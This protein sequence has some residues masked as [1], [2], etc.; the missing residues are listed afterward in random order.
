MKKSSEKRPS[1]KV[2]KVVKPPKPYPDFPLTPHN[3]GK[4]Q[5][6]IRNPVTGDSK[7]W[8]FGRWGKMVAGKME[9][10]PGDGWQEALA[11]YK[12]QADDLH[13]GRTPRVKNADGLTLKDLC[14]RFLTEKT[15]KKNAG[16]L[17]ERSLIDYRST[18]DRL[19]E[20]FGKDRLVDDIAAD[21]FGRLRAE[22]TKTWGP[23]RLS[24]EITRIKSVF[25]F[26]FDNALIEKPIRYGTQFDKPSK[27]V[28]RKHKATNGKKTIEAAD[29][30]KLLKAADPAMKAMILLG[31]NCGFGNSDVSNLQQGMIDLAGGWIDFPRPKTGI[32]RRC[33]LWPETIEALRKAIEVRPEPADPEAD[34]GCV[35]LT[36]RGQRL[37]TFGGSKVD[38]VAFDFA[39]LAKAVKVHRKGIG[40]YSLRH[41]FQT[42]ADTA[43]DPISTKAIMGHADGSM[44]GAYREWVSDD[45][46]R[47]VADHVHVWLF[48][49]AEQK[50]D[51]SGLRL[52]VEEGGAA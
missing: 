25:K 14:N 36:I 13:A 3:S 38:R 40:F 1:R 49:K 23:V 46:L 8:Y 42:V 24:N 7:I 2:P 48:P 51:S 18:T 26:A 10:L 52:F 9:R 17:T 27:S 11:L 34:S 39:A 44:S 28:L 21:D 4:W 32:E 22:L 16:E 35:F 50:A 5:K 43:R 47:A 20:Q 12:A 45:N 37:V 33:P 29:I 31:V 15:R 41:V 30:R 6:K 19:I